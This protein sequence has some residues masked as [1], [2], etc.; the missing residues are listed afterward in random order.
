MVDGVEMVF[1]KEKMIE[2]LKKE[3]RADGINEEVLAIMDNLDGQ[4]VGTNSWH[5]RVYG[6]PVYT[7]HGKDGKDLDVNENDC[8]YKSEYEKMM[9][10]RKCQKHES[11]CETGG[12]TRRNHRG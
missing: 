7:C 8:V 1:S 10:E 6:E 9:K 2:R 3:G 5:R 4:P 11:D 12:E